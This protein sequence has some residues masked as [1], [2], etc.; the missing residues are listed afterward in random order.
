MAWT[1]DLLLAGLAYYASATELTPADFRAEVQAALD[2]KRAAFVRSV[3]RLEADVA[4]L[5]R[6]AEAERKRAAEAALLPVDHVVERVM[7]YEKHLHGQLTSTLHELERLQARRAGVA[8]IP[9]VIADL[10][11]SVTGTDE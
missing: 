9:P 10:Y 2:G 1:R 7:R 3:D 6:R 11:L 4:A 8:V 5:T